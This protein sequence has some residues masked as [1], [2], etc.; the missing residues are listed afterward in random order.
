MIDRAKARLLAGAL[1]ALGGVAG[2]IVLGVG[3]VRALEATPYPAAFMILA[4][5]VLLGLAGWAAWY[6]LAPDTSLDKEGEQ[7]VDAA[8]SALADLPVEV[9]RKMVS[10]RPMTAIALFSGLGALI[11]RRPDLAGKLIE[12]LMMRLM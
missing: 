6:F 9:L 2:A 10:E 12:R 5:L 1:A 3:L 7:L 8:S 11:A 4:A